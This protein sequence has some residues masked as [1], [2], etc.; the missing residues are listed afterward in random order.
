MTGLRAWFTNVHIELTM[1]SLVLY[2]GSR[3]PKQG[4]AADEPRR[5]SGNLW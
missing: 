2:A 5:V 3:L 4:A 1:N